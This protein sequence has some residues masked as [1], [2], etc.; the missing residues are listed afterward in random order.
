[1]YFVIWCVYSYSKFVI[2]DNGRKEW[3][4]ILINGYERI[5][6]SVKNVCKRFNLF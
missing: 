3:S 6:L 2:M 4:F 1:M 5:N